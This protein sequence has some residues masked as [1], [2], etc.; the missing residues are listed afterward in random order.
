MLQTLSPKEIAVCVGISIR[1]GHGHISNLLIDNYLSETGL[2][3]VNLE[4]LYI[5][6]YAKD[7]RAFR[8]MLSLRGSRYQ[9]YEECI[10]R[11]ALKCP[12][13]RILEEIYCLNPKLRNMI[14]TD[15]AK[16]EHFKVLEG[17]FTGEE[18]QRHK[19]E[20]LAWAVRE[21]HENVVAKLC[22]GEEFH[23]S[24]P[25]GQRLSLLHASLKC[26]RLL[27]FCMLSSKCSEWL[28]SVLTKDF[29]EKMIH[30]GAVHILSWVLDYTFNASEVLKEVQ[31]PI[32]TALKRGN[33]DMVTFLKS[34]HVEEKLSY[35][36]DSLIKHCVIK[37]DYSTLDY[38]R[39]QRRHR[40]FD[41]SLLDLA[42]LNKQ[43]VMYCFLKTFIPEEDEEFI[44]V[45][46]LTR[47]I[48][49]GDIRVTREV[50]RL[51]QVKNSLAK[52]H[53]TPLRAAATNFPFFVKVLR[54]EPALDLISVAK[55]LAVIFSLND[56][57]EGIEFLVNYGVNFS[58][59]NYEE[60]LS[61]INSRCLYRTETSER[62]LCLIQEK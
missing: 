28:E 58:L 19:T 43:V 44:R 6:I 57:Q 48:K 38:I 36:Y 46:R 37:G 3:D 51:C 49:T 9:M 54:L 1:H 21:N 30:Y 22:L 12:H 18:L 8:K 13:V 61:E 24:L 26:D 39:R 16:N 4:P 31:E 25:K 34:I 40:Y 53:F 2:L 17:L 50:H 29:V 59:M 7:P 5:A 42:I 62:L 23:L 15:L 35:K 10:L 55:D 56:C 47:A 20:L 14:I 45:E 11:A 27:I 60:V 52:Y 33:L 32:S 41:V